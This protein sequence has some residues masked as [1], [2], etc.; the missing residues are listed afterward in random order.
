MFSD[1]ESFVDKTGEKDFSCNICG[2]RYTETSEPELVNVKRSQESIPPA[3]ESIPSSLK[4]FSIRP[5]DC[6]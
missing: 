5:L 4:G 2:Y 1:L 6:F 3:L